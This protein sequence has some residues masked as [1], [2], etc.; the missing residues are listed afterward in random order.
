MRIHVTL[1][2]NDVATFSISHHTIS[3][4]EATFE[5]THHM[6]LFEKLIINDES[7]S[8]SNIREQSEYDLKNGEIL[9]IEWYKTDH[10]ENWKKQISEILKQYTHGWTVGYYSSFKALKVL[11]DFQMNLSN[12]LTQF[13]VVSLGDLKESFYFFNIVLCSYG[14]KGLNTFGYG[15]TYVIDFLR[16]KSNKKVVREHLQLPKE[17]VLTYSERVKAFKPAYFVIYDST[18]KSIVIVIRGIFI[19]I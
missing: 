1:D 4:K 12:D 2:T 9:L 15:N 14:W 13:P 7:I 16:P 10:D 11:K 18:K 3:G 6:I 17:H 8:L 19:F 5:I